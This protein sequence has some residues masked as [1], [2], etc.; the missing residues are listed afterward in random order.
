MK[1]FASVPLCLICFFYY[2]KHPD[3]QTFNFTLV[4]IAVWNEI[5]THWKL[6]IYRFP[7]W[8]WKRSNSSKKDKRKVYVYG[9]QR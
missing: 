1:E 5:Q 3:T 4:L 9:I 7:G 8:N 2:Q 6:K